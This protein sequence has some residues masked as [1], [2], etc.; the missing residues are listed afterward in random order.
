ME[1][2][3]LLYGGGRGAGGG[4]DRSRS[5]WRRRLSS[6]NPL[7]GSS[8]PTLD[9]E[10][11]FPILPWLSPPPPA[12]LTHDHLHPPSR[13][14]IHLARARA[15]ADRPSVLRIMDPPSS[16]LRG[17][18]PH[19]TPPVSSCAH[20]TDPLASSPTPSGA[21]P[22]PAQAQAPPP[23]PPLRVLERRPASH[24]CLRPAHPLR[25]PP[26]LRH[27]ST[28]PPATAPVPQTFSGIR[29]WDR[30]PCSQLSGPAWHSSLP[31]D[32][33]APPVPRGWAGRTG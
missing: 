29:N 20:A 18:L 24:P 17:A 15:R 9:I 1:V 8:H 7:T 21:Q 3:R 26:L 23:A 25:S 31:H 4:P 10:L 32:L 19:L 22:A 33:A 11:C 28:P 16:L 12:P 6:T 13:P 30:H 14:F 27:Q 2:V 5:R